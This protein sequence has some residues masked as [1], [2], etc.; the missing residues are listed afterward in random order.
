MSVP[1]STVF[2]DF[3]MNVFFTNEVNDGIISNYGR[4][5]QTALTACLLLLLLMK[6]S[7]QCMEVFLLTFKAWSKFV[8]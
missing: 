4:L 2:M 8:E 6:R 5:L 1:V 7:L 3:M